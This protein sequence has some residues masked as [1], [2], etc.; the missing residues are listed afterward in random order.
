MNW[1]LKITLLYL[2]FVGMILTF[3]VK[4]SMQE[5]HMVTDDYYQEELVYEDQIQKIKLTKELSADI[6]ISY[7]KSSDK[8]VL[9]FPKVFEEI[10]GTILLYRPSDS[11]LDQTFEIDVNEE[12]IQEID[13]HSIQSG[14]WRIKIDWVGDQHEFYQE[15]V[16]VKP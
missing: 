15:K 5:F 9:T 6:S 7:K 11:D 3:V 2:G 16:I 1:G 14:M 12:G 8:L 13:S 4:A 10:R